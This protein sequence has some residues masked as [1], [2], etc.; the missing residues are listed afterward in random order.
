MDRVYSSFIVFVLS[1][2]L[3]APAWAQDVIY[4][5]RGRKENFNAAEYERNS[6]FLGLLR[7]VLDATKPEYGD[8]L[9]LPKKVPARG[10]RL[11]WSLANKA[12]LD[13]LWGN[14]HPKYAS[15]FRKINIDLLR[16]HGGIIVLLVHKDRIDE[17]RHITSLQQLAP[18]K[19]GRNAKSAKK[20]L[21][22]KINLNVLFSHNAGSVVKNLLMGRYD[23]LPVEL[24]GSD[25]IRKSHPD[26]VELP[27]LAF[28]NH[29][30]STYFVHKDNKR[31]HARITRGL[32]ILESNG[33]FAKHFNTHIMMSP[34]R[35][36]DLN[37]AIILHDF[38]QH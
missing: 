18:F 16:G 22:K 2:L 23:V 29:M 33:Q 38:T 4:Y 20:E 37:T 19:L 25:L 26:I 13:V 11:Q 3:S 8:Y 7:M 5:K 34:Y 31:L 28:K 32:E 12:G 24:Y 36:F 1:L 14:P 17:F 9:L 35:R 30:Q 15:A 6:Y 10:E 27:N 21:F